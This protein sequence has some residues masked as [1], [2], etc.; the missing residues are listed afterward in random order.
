MRYDISS[1]ILIE[2]CR[3]EILR[4]LVGLSVEESTVLE[5][6]P[7]ETVSLKR[8]DYPMLV[9]DED[10]RQ[11]LVVLEVQ[12]SWEPDVPLQLLEYRCRYVLQYGVNALS[13]V[14]LLRPSRQATD[15][16]EDP[17]VSFHFRL[18]RV[19]DFDA[20][21]IIR[22]GSLCLMPFVPLMRHGEELMTEADRL[23][24]ES[25]LPRGDKADM[26][27]AMAILSGLVSTRL[28]QT[29]L[30]RRRDIMIESAA[31]DLIKQEGVQEGIQEGIQEG[32]LRKSREAVLEV[33]E[34]RF[35][36]VPRSI[37][38]VIGAIDDPVTL[39]TLLRK[40]IIV[41]SLDHFRQ[42]VDEIL[43]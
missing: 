28:P 10:G 6:L 19:Y 43:R 1:K 23:L 26:L 35:D 38:S 13:C 27:T 8:S 42:L 41:E 18:V 40:A 4:R 20:K 36:F 3:E 24:Y 30:A 12:S 7:Q 15:F 2:K 5:Q 14:L 11:L 32:M 25:P 22:E 21:D 33:L 37:S 34:A 29:L 39:K 9:T 16:Y 17:E 31:Y